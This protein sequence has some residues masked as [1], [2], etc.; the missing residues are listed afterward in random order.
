MNAYEGLLLTSLIFLRTIYYETKFILKN[1]CVIPGVLSR[2]HGGSE[3][4]LNMMVMLLSSFH[5]NNS[6]T[7]SIQLYRDDSNSSGFV[8]YKHCVHSSKLEARLTCGK[9]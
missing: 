9:M 6:S 7:F 5:S 3:V 2:G 1:I 4:I 8:G